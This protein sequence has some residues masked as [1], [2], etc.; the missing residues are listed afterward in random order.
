MSDIFFKEFFISGLKEEIHA[1][2]L[3]AHPTTWLEASQRAQE[4]QKVVNAQIKKTP[5][6][7]PSPSHYFSPYQ[8]LSILST[9]QDPQVNHE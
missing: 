5:I 9:P 3:M 7:S 6:Y 2:V 8:S 1:Q 4:A